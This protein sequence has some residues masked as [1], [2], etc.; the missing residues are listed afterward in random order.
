MESAVQIPVKQSRSFRFVRVPAGESN[1]LLR[2]INGFLLVDIKEA[3][4]YTGF[5]KDFIRDL[6]DAG[7]LTAL[8]ANGTLRT[9]N[10][11]GNRI[12]RCFCLYEWRNL[13]LN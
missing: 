12:P 5:G 1:V 4:M 2:E 7:K 8:N 9:N 10:A 6:Q 13:D 11:R 3:K